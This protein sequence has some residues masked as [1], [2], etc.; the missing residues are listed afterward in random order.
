VAAASATRPPCGYWL[1]RR[2]AAA[3]M[4]PTLLPSED[5]LGNAAL[6]RTFF[7]R[8]CASCCSVESC[9]REPAPFFSVARWQAV[10]SERV[11]WRQIL[12]GAGLVRNEWRRLIQTRGLGGPCTSASPTLSIIA[13]RLFRLHSWRLQCYLLP[14]SPFPGSHLPSSAAA[15]HYKRRF[16]IPRMRARR[17]I[18]MPSVGIMRDGDTYPCGIRWPGRV[19]AGG[20][21]WLA[22]RA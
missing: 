8:Y 6:Y 10:L 21:V 12:L 16:M 19:A 1:G 17:V 15:G 2:Y 20:P 22:A 11:P 14:L 4:K 7:S 18:W 5:S 13:L 9:P 3:A